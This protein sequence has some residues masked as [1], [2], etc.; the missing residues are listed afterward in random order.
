MIDTIQFNIYPILCIILFVWDSICFHEILEWWMYT[1]HNWRLWMRS[2]YINSYIQSLIIIILHTFV[3]YTQKNMYKE[4]FS[5]SSKYH[6]FCL[7]WNLSKSKCD[8]KITMLQKNKLFCIM[9]HCQWSGTNMHHGHQLTM[10]VVNN[11]SL[12]QKKNH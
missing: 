10:L 12:K 7:N 5:W 3:L 11:E 2:I 4:H 6:N 1:Y 8:W 9:K